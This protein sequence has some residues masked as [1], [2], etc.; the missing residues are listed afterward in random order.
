MYC[1][2]KKIKKNTAVVCVCCWFLSLF[3]H[4][5]FAF[6]LFA[7]AAL[8]TIR[9]PVSLYWDSFYVHHIHQY[10]V[11]LFYLFA[12]PNQAYTTN[13]I[14]SIFN[15]CIAEHLIVADTYT[16]YTNTY[17]HKTALH[18][19]QVILI[20]LLYGVRAT[21]LYTI[22]TLSWYSLESKWFC[23]CCFLWSVLSVLRISNNVGS[24]FVFAFWSIWMRVGCS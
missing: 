13:R 11:F 3:F 4:L 17:A 21:M 14:E 5:L 19:I 8:A 9:S 16:H 18:L 23:C 10:L 6:I 15:L 7:Y 20:A 1:A 12:Q 24:W 22:R 2:R